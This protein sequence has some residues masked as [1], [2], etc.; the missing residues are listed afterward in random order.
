MIIHVF[1]CFYGWS[2]QS[3]F[4][5]SYTCMIR[6]QDELAHTNK[7]K[8]LLVQSGQR[9]IITSKRIHKTLVFHWVRRSLASLNYFTIHQQDIKVTIFRPLLES[10]YKFNLR[11][12]VYLSAICIFLFE[13]NI[14]EPWNSKV[15]LELKY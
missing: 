3:T 11:T 14:N 5:I 10:F 8:Q 4:L 12:F 15:C 1:H 9:I 7:E 13:Q 6:W 2:S